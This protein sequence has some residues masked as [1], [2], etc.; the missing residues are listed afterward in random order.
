M[1]IG[2]SCYNDLRARNDSSAKAPT[3]RVRQP[4]IADQAGRAAEP[5]L[6]RRAKRSGVPVVAIGGITAANGRARWSRRVPTH[7]P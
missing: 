2:V 7:S 3:G 4:F 1:L 6:L 5:A